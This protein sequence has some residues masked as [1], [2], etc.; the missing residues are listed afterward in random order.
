MSTSLTNLRDRLLERVLDLL[1][2]QWCALGVFGNAP[3][4]GRRIIDPEALVAATCSFGRSDPRMFDEMLDW[5]RA[6]G[7]LV[8]TQRLRNLVTKQG[9]DGAA[10]VSAVAAFLRQHDKSARWRSLA[11]LPRPAG[12]ESLFRFRDGQPHPGFGNL[13]AVFAEHGF[14]RGR[15]D[16]RGYSQSFDPRFPACLGMRLRALFGV[17]VRA[18]ASLFL[19]AH[20]S[21]TNPTAMARLTGYAQRSVQDALAMMARSGWVRVRESGRE[22]VYTLAP[23]FAAALVP[24]LDNG[25]LWTPWPILWRY[26]GTLLGELRKTG[27]EKLSPLLQAGEL[28][29]ALTALQKQVASAGFAAVFSTPI[30]PRGKEYLDYI[31]RTTDDLLDDLEE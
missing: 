9:L 31:L 20:P 2:R 14:Q 5:L 26:L 13:D 11:R 25:I 24:G 30:P 12:K 8:N 6:N 28:R 1:W 17:N 10:V 27:F 23:E 19:L 3:A 29:H 16:L 4:P 22:K 15:V 18:E 7:G 21:G